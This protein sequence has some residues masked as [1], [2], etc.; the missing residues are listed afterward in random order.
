M[1]MRI[2]ALAINRAATVNAGADQ[3][4]CASSPQAQLAGAVGGSATGG[5]WSGGAGTFNPSA[6]ALNATYMPTAAEIAAG[7]VTLTLTT[8]AT[9]GPCAVASDDVRLTINPA[10]TA[11]AGADQAVC[12]S[13]LQ[14]QLAGAVGGGAAS[15]S[16]SGGAG[17]YSPNASALSAIYTPSAAEI[18]AGG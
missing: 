10:A 4:V 1:V 6:S 9:G 12:S 2:C 16:W 11:D 8:N 14:I 7:G 13:S 3:A 17:T 5:S 18:A 15:G